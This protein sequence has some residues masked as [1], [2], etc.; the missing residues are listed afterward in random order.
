MLNIYYVGKIDGKENLALVFV[1]NICQNC[2]KNKCSEE[3][4]ENTD[5]AIKIR[6]DKI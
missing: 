3:D 6:Q 5:F 2:Q 1:D 4:W